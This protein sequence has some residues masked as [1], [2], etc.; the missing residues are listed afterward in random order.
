MITII[1]TTRNR[2]QM[3]LE[4][5]LSVA[6][7]SIQPKWIIYVDDEMS[8]YESVLRKVQEIVPQCQIIGGNRVSRVQALDIAHRHCTTEYVGW[9]DDDDWLDNRCIAMCQSVINTHQPR[10]V[11]TDYYDVIGKAVLGNRNREPF[12]YA[13]FLQQNI[14]HHFR[15]YEMELYRECGGVNLNLDSAIDY[16]LFL[17]MLYNVIPYKIDMP[18]YY[19]RRHGNRMSV[20]MS[21]QQTANARRAI[22]DNQHRLIQNG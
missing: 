7:Q 15:V 12:S 22:S 18:L 3:L 2:P 13:R 16:E 8:Y 17:R 9:L 10:F 21:R 19:Y 4:C 1:T 6:V 11:Y 5:A 20:T 14:V